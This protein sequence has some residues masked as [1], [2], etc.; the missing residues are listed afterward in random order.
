MCQSPLC[1]LETRKTVGRMF[2][3]G[4]D[5]VSGKESVRYKQQQIEKNI[6][7]KWGI[8]YD[9]PRIEWERRSDRPRA[10][11]GLAVPLNL[12]LARSVICCNRKCMNF[13]I[14][15]LESEADMLG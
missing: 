12:V 5:V 13:A 10:V 15:M 9:L 1:G 4:T 6:M 8:S 14:L 7:F 11:V 2:A 3:V